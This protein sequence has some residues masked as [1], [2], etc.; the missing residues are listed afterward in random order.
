MLRLKIESP[1]F[2]VSVRTSRNYVLFIMFNHNDKKN[3]FKYRGQLK[4]TYIF[5]RKFPLKLL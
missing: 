1:I 3:L 2:S 5:P 4:I